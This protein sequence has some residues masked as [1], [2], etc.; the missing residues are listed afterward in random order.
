MTKADVV[1]ILLFIWKIVRIVTVFV[2][3]YGFMALKYTFKAFVIALPATIY[4]IT[5]FLGGVAGGA[6]DAA[7]SKASSRRPY[8]RIWSDEE[9]SSYYHR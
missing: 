6:A 8:H 4:L 9:N 2:V 5:C 7:A 3:V 1:K